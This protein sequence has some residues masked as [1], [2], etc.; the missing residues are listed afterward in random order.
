M[1]HFRRRTERNVRVVVRARKITITTGSRLSQPRPARRTQSRPV[2]SVLP[3]SID[4]LPTVTSN[5]EF[6]RVRTFLP[7]VEVPII[8]EAANV[9]SVCTDTQL[10]IA[11][12]LK[13]WISDQRTKVDRGIKSRLVSIMADCGKWSNQDQGLKDITFTYLDAGELPANF[14][15][16][17]D[18]AK[19]TLHTYLSPGLMDEV[20][21]AFSEARLRKALLG[22]TGGS[23]QCPTTQQKL[24]AA[25]YKHVDVVATERGDDLTFHE[26]CVAV[27]QSFNYHYRLEQIAVILHIDMVS[28]PR[29]LCQPFTVPS[30]TGVAK[31]RVVD[32]SPTGEGR[33][34]PYWLI[35]Q[36]RESIPSLPAALS[37]PGESNDGD[38]RHGDLLVDYDT[39]DGFAKIFAPNDVFSKG[40][41]LGVERSLSQSLH[42]Y[43]VCVPLPTGSYECLHSH[44]VTRDELYAT[45]L[46]LAKGHADYMH[47]FKNACPNQTI[48]TRMI[49]NLNSGR[50]GVEDLGPDGEL[51]PKAEQRE[52]RKKTYVRK[53]DNTE[54]DAARPLPRTSPHP[55]RP[56]RHHHRYH[57]ARICRRLI[58]G[59]T[60][61]KS[62]STLRTAAS[63][64]S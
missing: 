15:C 54:K 24:I 12:C 45:V 2:A 30:E 14:M 32:E 52:T 55:V 46:A 21:K 43:R 42:F 18:K 26:K 33:A 20:D 59:R 7:N 47:W 60:T 29:D 8:D 62:C 63:M 27:E 39:F 35:G 22:Y 17:I 51:L 38:K 61:T 1:R 19:D 11:N 41:R 5:D 6:E 50:C 28:T 31:T 4:S 56:L 44:T 49:T 34:A 36:R 40:E 64:M 13:P 57:L 23:V 3:A 53:R 37:K 16:T 9:R 48:P 25:V 58:L 10:A